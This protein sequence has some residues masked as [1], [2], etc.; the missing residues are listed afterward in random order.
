M[1]DRVVLALQYGGGGIGSDAMMIAP[2]TST[3]PAKLSTRAI[4]K[5]I[6]S[7]LYSSAG[8][9]S[10]AAE[11]VQERCQWPRENV[12]DMKRHSPRT[13]AYGALRG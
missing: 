10:R 4:S 6:I 5:Q 11:T 2:M 12:A 3:V 1:E 7:L 8:A 13:R 9:L